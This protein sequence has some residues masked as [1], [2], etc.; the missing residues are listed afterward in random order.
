MDAY[1]LVKTLHIVSATILLGTGLGIAALMVAGHASTEPDAQLFAARMTVRA[2]FIFTLPAVILQPAT[3]AWLVLNRGFAWTEGW[4]LLVY[5]L[6]LLAGLCWLP[7]VA[8]QIRMRAM[9]ERRAQEGAFDDAAYR[10]LFRLWLGL[11]FPAFSAVIAI[12]W[13]MVAKPSW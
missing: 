3:G 2:D 12:F 13:L 9:L 5:G 11:G 10:R 8:I 4:L 1:F 6:Y 7:V